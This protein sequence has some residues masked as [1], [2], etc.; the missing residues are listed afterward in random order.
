MTEE[1]GRRRR[2]SPAGMIGGLV[3]VAALV[4]IVV[5]IAGG[6]GD[7]GDEGSDAPASNAAASNGDATRAETLVLGQFRPPTGKIGNPY[8]A[9]SDALV[10][11][12]L[13]ELVYEPLFYI[14]YQ[15]GESEPWLAESYEYSDDNKTITL[16]L[17]D[18]VTW[19]DGEQFGAADVVFTL[20]QIVKAKA[21]YRAA[22][23]QAAIKSVK[24][25]SPTQV[26]IKLKTANPR[27]VDTELSSN[28]YTANFIPMPKHIFEGKKFD[29]FAFFDL[30]KGWP[31][32]TGPY[33]LTKVDAS[34]ATLTRDEDWWAAKAGVEDVPAPKRVVYTVPGPEDTAVSSLETNKLDYAGQSV[35]TVAGFIAARKQNPNLVNWD[36]DLGWLDPCP[37]SLTI[38]TQNAPW[39]DP[40]MRWALNAAIDKQQFSQLFN[41]PGEPTPARSPYPEYPQLTELLDAN[42]SLFDTYPT[43]QHDVAKAEQT[44]EGK[45]YT[46]DGGVWTKDGE[47]LSLKLNIFNPAAL[48]PVWGD[49]A[50]LLSQQLKEAGIKV[51]LQPGDFNLVAS[52]RTE[53]KFDAQSWFECGSVT[54]P[55]ST[56]NRYT[57]APGNDN[58]GKWSNARFNEIV[59][60]MGQLPPGDEQIGDLF[61]EAMDIWL[62]ELPVI[63]LV[64]RPTPIVMNQTH[65]KG[66]PTAEN[67]YTQPAPW[68]MNFHQVITRLEPAGDAQ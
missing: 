50:Q 49:A 21:P 47:A 9:A 33:T 68:G 27:F 43:L 25:V 65:W 60:E 55:W 13:H 10:S 67:G 29:T 19:N 3:A 15:S 8:V 7:D 28:V 12:G 2:L 30:D 4:L 48:G 36:G 59:A 37:F 53:G 39:D 63:P 40:D 18:D 45:G 62:E 11:D 26:E 22:N 24:E 20:E 38:N 44:F 5:A 64:Q 14:N 23:I 51:D 66:W 6:G 32:G 1:D 41:T 56:L 46:K 61:T 34:S 31:V 57:D 58:A 17:R 54:D 42:Q 16:N 35:P 52:T